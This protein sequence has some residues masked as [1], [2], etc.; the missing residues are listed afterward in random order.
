[1]LIVPSIVPLHKSIDMV[2]WLQMLNRIDIID[3]QVSYPN[4]MILITLDSLSR[5]F[6]IELR[7][8]LLMNLTD[9]IL[10]KYVRDA[11]RFLGIIN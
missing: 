11:V 4:S 8:C 1:M 6:L 9:R 3:E 10:Q 7:R 2:V 5:I